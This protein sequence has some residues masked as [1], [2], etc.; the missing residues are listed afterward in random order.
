MQTPAAARARR[1]GAR[2]MRDLAVPDGSA[3][4]AAHRVRCQPPR[5]VAA[6]LRVL[7]GLG[8]LLTH[9]DDTPRRCA[10][11]STRAIASG[12]EVSSATETSCANSSRVTGTPSTQA[13][14]TTVSA[15]AATPSL[16]TASDACGWTASGCMFVPC[17]ATVGGVPRPPGCI[18]TV[19][20]LDADKP[21]VWP[22]PSLQRGHERLELRDDVAGQLDRSAGV[23]GRRALG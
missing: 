3:R 15:A 14:R 8:H 2:E 11:A 16:S 17:L 23:P 9:R 1:P 21:K 22:R 4:R 12:A 18:P 10:T 19:P 20:R 7:V 13:R 6:A 5:W